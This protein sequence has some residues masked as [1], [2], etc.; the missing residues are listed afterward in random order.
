MTGLR[1]EKRVALS[2]RLE[3]IAW[4]LAEAIPG[5]IN[6][7]PLSQIAVSFGIVIDKLRLLREESAVVSK[8]DQERR[9]WAEGKLQE[10]M[11]DFGLSRQEGLELIEKDASTVCDLLTQSSNSLG[12]T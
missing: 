7:A 5:K 8:T 4:Q 11:R 9:R 3:E 10:L 6:D 1:G 2:K 12:M